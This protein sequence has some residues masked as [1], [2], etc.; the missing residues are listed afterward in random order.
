MRTILGYALVLLLVAI[1]PPAVAEVVD[2]APGG[3]TS[4]NAVTVAVPAAE[5][6]SA[7][8]QEVGRWWN[9]SHTYS[10]DAANMR[11]DARPQ[12]C[13]CETLP[14]GGGVRHLDVVFVAPGRS[15]RLTGGLGPLQGEAVDGS[16]T[17]TLEEG[18]GEA[19]AAVTTVTVTYKVHGYVPGGMEGWAGP[20]DG[21]V[22]EQLQR[23]GRFV[24]TGSPAEPQPAGAAD[25]GAG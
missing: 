17:W 16:M 4:R 1:A 9:P 10:G 22:G 7:L 5:V 18:A 25:G 8:V 14:E 19:G 21:V 23:L 3:F 20:V 13:F 24:E 2:S 12:G 6:F 11:I 15:L